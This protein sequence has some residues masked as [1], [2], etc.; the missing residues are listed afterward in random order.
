MG[1]FCH[2]IKG[3]EALSLS[4]EYLP[5]LNNL[6]IFLIQRRTNTKQAR[7]SLYAYSTALKET[8]IHE[9]QTKLQKNT[10]GKTIC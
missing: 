8:D 4:K 5:R 9:K 6:I 3:Y 10:I 2:Q 7:Q 1:F